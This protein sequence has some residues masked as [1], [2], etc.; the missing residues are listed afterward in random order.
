MKAPAP[1]K[2]L[3]NPR[4]IESEYKHWRLRTM[5]AMFVGYSV[6]Y[7]VRKN[8]SAATPA[9]LTELSYT[10]TEIGLIWSVLYLTYGVSKFVNGI[11]GDRSNPRYFMAVGLL[12]SALTNIFFGMS[13]SLVVFAIFWGLNGWFQGM[14]WPPCARLLTHWYSANERGTK[15]AIWNTSH[16][17]GGGLILILGGYLVQ[18]YGWRSSFYVP[19]AL[20]LVCAWFL[21]NRLRDTPE[22]LGL[23]AVEK[24]RNDP[25]PD[26]IVVEQGASTKEIL[27]KYVLGNRA[28]WFLALANFFVYLVRYGAMDWA[29]TFLV[30]VKHSTIAKASMKTAMFEFLGIAGAF[31]AGWLSDKYFKGRRSIVNVL[32]MAALVFAVV[33]FWIIPPGNPMLDALALSAVG[34]L[35]YGPQMLVGLC[36]AELAPRQAAA[37]ATGFTGFFGYLG[38]IASGLGTGIVVDRY[39]WDGGFLFFIAAALLGT[40]FFLATISKRRVQSQAGP[41]WSAA[42]KQVPSEG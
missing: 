5:Y 12:L 34:F 32:Y 37:T 15:W 24:F 17:V 7:F 21:M 28:I 6:F 16:Q 42:T 33:E 35:V 26:Q 41:E 29:P 20:A 38:G 13:S 25:E 39:G 2:T 9:M 22:S 40:L 19:A 3:S 23:P 30:E 14:G 18:H 31:L 11:W 27:F 1:Q 8:L 4:Q 36:A 10:K